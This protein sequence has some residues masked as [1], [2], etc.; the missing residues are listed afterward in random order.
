MRGVGDKTGWTKLLSG[1]LLAPMGIVKGKNDG[2]KGKKLGMNADSGRDQV[3][4]SF[5]SRTR[6]TRR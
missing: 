6:S 2:D 1:N 5:Q 3:F 4:A